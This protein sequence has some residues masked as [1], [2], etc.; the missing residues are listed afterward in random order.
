M[1]KFKKKKKGRKEGSEGEKEGR[2]KCCTLAYYS[3]TAKSKKSKSNQKESIH[4]LQM[5]NKKT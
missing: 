1:I 3:K 2:K 5:N 4:Y